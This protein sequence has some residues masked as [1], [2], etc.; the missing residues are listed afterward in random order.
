MLLERRQEGWRERQFA[1][2]HTEAQKGGIVPLRRLRAGPSC[3]TQHCGTA[4][5]RNY[6]YYCYCYRSYWY[7]VLVESQPC[8]TKP[9]SLLTC[10]QAVFLLHSMWAGPN[11]ATQCRDIPVPL[12]HDSSTSKR[13]F[14]NQYSIVTLVESCG[15][16]LLLM[17]AC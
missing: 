2:P 3:A 13:P 16:G 8:G 12:Q 17:G 7:N 14:M 10:R 4:H 9:A 6:R 11:A 5:D 1:C 15:P